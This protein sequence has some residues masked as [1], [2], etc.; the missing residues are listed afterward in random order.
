M[1]KEKV[2]KPTKKRVLENKKKAIE[3][4]PTQKKPKKS[5]T[6]DGDEQWQKFIKHQDSGKKKSM[7][8]TTTTT[9]SNTSTNNN[10]EKKSKQEKKKK[11]KTN[12][13]LKQREPCDLMRN[14]AKCL[15]L[16]KQIEYVETI[17]EENHQQKALAINLMP[18]RARQTSETLA[19][20]VEHHDVPPM[21]FNDIEFSIAMKRMNYERTAP[22][23]TNNNGEQPTGSAAA[24]AAPRHHAYP[25]QDLM[26]D[27]G[28]F[29][30]NNEH[31]EHV[32]KCIIKDKRN[33]IT[34]AKHIKA[35]AAK[36]RSGNAS[37]LKGGKPGA[38]GDTSNK[39]L[40]HIFGNN[41]HS[42]GYNRREP[43]ARHKKMKALD[44]ADMEARFRAFYKDDQ[45][46]DGDDET[47]YGKAPSNFKMFRKLRRDHGDKF[48]RRSE[49]LRDCATLTPKPDIEELS[50]EYI[51]EFR[52]P[53]SSGDALCENG[54]RCIFNRFSP[55]RTAQYI[56]KVFYT[57]REKAQAL[58]Q[59]QQSQHIDDENDCDV[60]Q[61]PPRFC[62]DCLLKNWTVQWKLN[63]RDGVIPERPINYFTVMCKP[64]QYSP[65]CMLSQLFNNK[66]TGII[67]HVP[68][69]S[70][71]NRRII[72]HQRIRRYDN[73]HETI[74]VPVL[75][76]T[77]MDF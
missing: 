30:I 28:F 71:N 13:L 76:E 77:G 41:F 74:S 61:V 67:G 40:N 58:K 25:L 15:E 7:T 34:Y 18:S 14:E 53:P 50:K 1:E 6:V 29:S 46:E 52:Q 43:K 47:N 26:G 65:H 23:N 9:T 10:N 39:K 20:G 49:I 24:A 45:L 31:V 16:A 72:T 75:V 37:A 59:Q 19:L 62:I 21:A 70:P 17:N 42:H 60:T 55:D 8:T 3:K 11:K 38:R 66:Q 33:D 27:Q 73:K 44:K 4:E 22:T 54:V 69:Y 32:L 35:E 51:L 48:A 56:G 63:I 64:G 12:P 57:E 5:S 68:R 2:R 36:A